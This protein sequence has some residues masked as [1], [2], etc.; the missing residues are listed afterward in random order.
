MT[1]ASADGTLKT[2]D[3]RTGALV[4]THKGHTGVVNGVSVAPAPSEAF[5]NGDGEEV[6]MK[7]RNEVG[8]VVVSGGD[9]GVSLI[10]RI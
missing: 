2:W 9:E 5:P 4:A 10:W 8:Q 1:S 6:E 7:P 3:I